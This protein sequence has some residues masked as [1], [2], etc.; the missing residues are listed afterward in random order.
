MKSCGSAE[1]TGAPNGQAEFTAE[2]AQVPPQRRTEKLVQFNEKTAQLEYTPSTQSEFWSNTSDANS[3]EEEDSASSI[4]DWSRNM[5]QSM[6]GG[7][8]PQ[9]QGQAGASRCS[10]RCAKECAVS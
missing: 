2:L 4:N 9:A 3:D 8:Q 7:A 5:Q 10:D 6:N 1:G